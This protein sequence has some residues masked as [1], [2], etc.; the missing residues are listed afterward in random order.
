MIYTKQGDKGTTS[1]VGGTRVEKCHER[2]ECYGTVDELNSHVGV[3]AELARTI[4]GSFYKE[5]KEVQN[6]LFV[7]Q[8]LLATE[9]EALLGRLPQLPD[10]ATRSLELRIDE[11]Y[12]QLPHPNAF[13]IPG[14]NMASAQ[15]HVAR[16]VCRRTE[17]LLVK[18]QHS[19]KVP[20]AIPPYINRLSDYLFAL[21]RILVVKDGK[22]EDYWSAKG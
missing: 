12:A 1:L 6:N 13:I 10:D 9:D 4:D 11:Y 5:L 8:T 17:R 16:C 3:V 14:G 20:D 2:V 19:C 18:L 7:I 22:E 21:A 15:C